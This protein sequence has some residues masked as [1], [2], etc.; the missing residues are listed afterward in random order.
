MK[1]SREWLQTYFKDSLPSGEK[2]AE[3]LTMHA[4]EIEGIEK[5]GK[6]EVLD[7]KV[8]PNRAHDCLSHYGI[9]KEISA[10]LD[11]PLSKDPFEKENGL[12]PKTTSVLVSVKT[13]KVTRFS[14]ALI[15]NVKIGPSPQWLQARLEALGQKSINNIV[16][17]TNYAMFDLGQPL[18]VFD[19]DKLSTKEGTVKISVR[20]SGAG[21]TLETLDDKIYDLP[22]ETIL[23]TEDKDVQKILGMGGIKGGKEA[24]IT[25][26]TKNIILEAANFDAKSIRLTSK[27][28]RLRT[29]ASVRFE[30][31]I[32]PELPRF[33]LPAVVKLILEIAGGNLEGYT[34]Y[35]PRPRNPY[36]TGVSLKE[37]NSLL[38][39]SL[40]KKDVE[41]ILK[42]L[43][44]PY[45]VIAPYEKVLSL[46]KSLVG[47]AYSYGASISY[48]APR[49]F[50]C[51]SFTAYLFAQAGISIP[52]ISID[53]LFYGEEIQ[54]ADLKAGDLVF[55]RGNGTVHTKT[56]YFMKGKNFEPG[57]SHV[58]IY[59]GQG[60]VIH[61]SGKESRGKVLEE[62]LSES[63]D[64]KEVVSYRRI[65]QDDE[66]RF[67]VTAPFERLDLEGSADLI[68]EIGRIYGLEKITSA[69]QKKE[70]L[71]KI[72][73]NFFYINKIK[74]FFQERGFSEVYTYAMRNSGTLEIEN[75]LASDKKYLRKNLTDGLKESLQK[76]TWYAPL[77]DLYDTGEVKIFEIGE[78]FKSLDT[79]E[80]LISIAFGIN[81]VKS[82]EKATL[83][84]KE[85]LAEE[86]QKLLDYLGSK[87]EIKPGDIDVSVA[88]CDLEE[89]IKNL[90]EV[91]AYDS[92][93]PSI[94]KKYTSLSPYPYLLR[95]IAVFVPET[96]SSGD[97]L[98]AIEKQAGK[99][100]VH[101]MLFDQ[102]KKER[103]IS[104]AFRLVFQS[105]DKTLS[106]AEVNEIMALIT[107]NLNHKN[108][109]QVR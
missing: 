109:W 5:T 13:K 59:L 35:Y 24:E 99:L 42:R 26:N 60:N 72:D 44:L 14:T 33:V 17:I 97:V 23:V 46:G 41:K 108:G 37:I 6:D 18:H 78:I 65:L 89:I 2:I 9:A 102:F 19:F 51:S 15:K 40:T 49:A 106:D 85:R 69:S 73:K 77:L 90:P 22:K 55:S 10:I 53:Q 58:G 75:P 66:R 20:E 25:E 47:S 81:R 76:N 52:R 48:D 28:L 70:T 74:H 87:K 63:P 45:E 54:E 64:F 93:K 1:I 62:A 67:V 86:F 68:E 98:T 82:K 100:L 103:K 107:E 32:A 57:V 16:D 39:E 8:L 27:F 94:Q 83:E 88:E 79:E 95:D 96:I 56:L 30:N 21:E 105:H 31:G 12:K 101:T 7:V 71:L 38:G 61:A 4:F 91:S 80:P 34:D 11:I 50:D 29:D 36:K 104:Y 3:A 92:L 43:H 84:T